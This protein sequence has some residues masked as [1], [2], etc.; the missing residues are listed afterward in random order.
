[1]RLNIKNDM[2]KFS[3][4]VIDNDK[5]NVVT[6]TYAVEGETIKTSFGKFKL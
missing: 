5:G 4:D 1:M 3:F 6:R 2:T